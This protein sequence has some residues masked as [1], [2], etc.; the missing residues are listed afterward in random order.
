MNAFR[1][2]TGLITAHV[3]VP[4]ARTPIVRLML[5]QP[6]GLPCELS[7]QNLL[8]ECKANLVRDLVRAETTGFIVLKKYLK[9]NF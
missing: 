1:K 9:M 4:D 7:V 6:K 5:R 3:P 2:E 8:S